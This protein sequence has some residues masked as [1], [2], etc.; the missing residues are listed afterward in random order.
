M[1][2]GTETDTMD[3]TT[4]YLGLDLKHPI[5]AS[6]SPLTKDLDGILRVVDAGA[7]AIVMASVYEEDIA[8]EEMA[9]A[10]LFEMGEESQPEASGYFPALSYGTPLDARLT[11]L[12]R[13]AERAGVPIIASLNGC[14]LA[15]WVDFASKMEQAG[16][17]AIE[18]NFWRVP[19]DSN[20]SGQEVEALYFTILRAVK[21]RVAIPVSVKLSPFLSAPGNMAKRLAEAGADGLVLF[22]RFYEPGFNPV[23]M[24]IEEDFRFSSSYDLRLPLMWT[25]LLSGHFSTDFAVSTGVNSG[26]DV[27]RC[28]LAGA[29]VTMVTSALLQYGPWHIQ[30]MLEEV[31]CWMEQKGIESIASVR[32][33]LAARGTPAHQAQFLREEY[34]SILMTASSQKI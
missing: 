18:L 10:A 23:S 7:A 19:T 2:G 21:A 22:N 30:T 9:E 24:S 6:A 8:R 5:V 25:G 3:L 32:G 26:A 27:I 33:R 12:Q 29:N 16:A 13:A 28:M 14:T 20:E 1:S 17:A 4:R 15:G 11:V 34:R 31:R